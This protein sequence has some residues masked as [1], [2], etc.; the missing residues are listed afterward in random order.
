MQVILFEVFEAGAE[1]K[2]GNSP[3]TNQTTDVQQPIN[4][5]QNLQATI[6]EHK[7]ATH[8]L[9]MH[10]RDVFSMLNNLG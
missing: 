7:G 9:F 8:V 5:R 1:D 10:V 3:M 2:A 4:S 6:K